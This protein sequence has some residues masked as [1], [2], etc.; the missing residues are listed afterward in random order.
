VTVCVAPSLKWILNS[1]SA[2][3]ACP[4]EESNV[5]PRITAV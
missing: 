2:D 1:R 4:F 5:C 3:M